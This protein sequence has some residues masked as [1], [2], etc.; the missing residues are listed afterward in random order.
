LAAAA[1]GIS[2]P[3]YADTPL[4]L[5]EPGDISIDGALD[6]WG[7]AAFFPLAAR[8]EGNTRVAVRAALAYDKSYLYVAGNVVDP[9]FVRTT[10]YAHNE[11]HVELLLSFPDEDGSYGRVYEVKLFA[12][13][14]GEIAGRVIAVGLGVVRGAEIVEATSTGGYTFEAKIPWTLFPQAAHTRVKI[15]GVVRYID[16]NGRSV[17]GIIGSA[18]ATRS[19]DM[20]FLATAPEQSVMRGLVR[21]RG[22]GDPTVDL[23]ANVAGDSMKERVLV[24]GRYLVVYGP[25]FRGGSEYFWS[26][27]EVDPDAGEL[28]LFE[29]RDVNGDGISEI[30]M[31]KRISRGGG[32]RELLQVMSFKGDNLVPIFEH[33][34]GIGSSI[35]TIENSVTFVPSGR[36]FNIVIALGTDVGYD[37]TNYREPAETERASLLL[38]W[39]TVQSRTYGWDR[40]KFVKRAE[41]SKAPGSVPNRPTPLPRPPAA[42][43]PRPPSPDELLEKVYAKYKLAHGISDFS[44]PTFD[45][46]TNV[47]GSDEVE[48]VICHGRDLVVF[49]KEFLSASGYVS[50]SMRQFASDADIHHVSAFDVTG[51]GQAEIIVRGS[52]KA[53]A[54]EELGGGELVREVIFM[55]RVTELSIKRVFAA[56]T[57]VSIGRNRIHSLLGFVPVAGGYAIE[58]RPGRAVGW[59]RATWPYRQ[60]VEAVSGLEPI[61]LPWTEGGVRYRF[62][63]ET[64]VR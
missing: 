33:E 12:G 24:Y 38:P 10:R 44:S 54:P 46:V 35:G 62:G 27:L 18:P 63:G 31:R 50:L 53:A 15:R 56:E 30:V 51:D 61:V 47:A 34:T 64:F 19:A 4:F 40:N 39:G 48:R 36:G 13:K 8:I 2:T 14:P 49:G 41:Q 22:L 26:D 42:P 16:G 1:L 5:T 45:F 28:P 43:P 7:N 17:A 60:D 9:S 20:P 32:W 21:D 55:Y 11:D 57:S 59:T 29:V 37:S 25:S 52:Q 6:D 3:A 58:L 23:V